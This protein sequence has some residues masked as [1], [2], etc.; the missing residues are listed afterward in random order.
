MSNINILFLSIGR[1]ENVNNNGLYTD[2]LRKFRDEGHNVY[3]ASPLER[4]HSKPTKYT[5]EHGIHFLRIKIGNLTKTNV[6]EKGITTV[7][8]EYIFTK[9]IKKHFNGI[10]FDLILYSTPPITFGKVISY[11]KKRDDAVT[12][13]LLKDI[14]P[15]NAVDL[16]ILNTK[17]PLYS[18]FRKKEKKLYEASDYIGCMSK[19]NVN[20]ILRNNTDLY[21][22]K[23]EISPN[24]IEPRPV[25]YFSKEN[26]EVF[27]QYEIPRN[28]VKLLYGGNLGKPQGI[29]FLIK[30]IDS[31]KFNEKI[32][33][34]IV[35]SG[36]QAYKLRKYL[37]EEQPKNL[38]LIERLPKEDYDR[39]LSICD[40]GLI[41]LD[42]RFTIPNFP[43]RLLSYMEASKPVLAATDKNTDIGKIIVENDFGN[44]CES[45][46]VSDFNDILPLIYMEN[47]R[48][49]MGRNGR[50]YL[51]ENYTIENS[52]EIILKHFK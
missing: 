44:W 48:V 31:N 10:K 29:D 26:F 35:G 43:S 6:I 38:T 39:L 12:Y 30:C 47:K 36:T 28:K 19:E 49:E 11:I 41:F 33:F 50:N 23:V 9:M 14:F 1:L 24:T 22:T 15:Q 46:N 37:K 17:N 18:F 20:F 32:H 21:E 42:Y 52:Y 2:L 5:I 34:V 25:S 40:V 13:L 7:T 27:Q 51:E 4:K 16:K 3:V 45:K 8:L